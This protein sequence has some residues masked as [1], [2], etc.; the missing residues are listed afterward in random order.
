MTAVH[1]S[2]GAGSARSLKQV[3]ASQS[4]VF[5]D[6][7]ADE[8]NVI[9]L[10]QERHRLR[11]EL[12]TALERRAAMGRH[13]SVRSKGSGVR[14][15]SAAVGQR[16]RVLGYMAALV[17]VVVGGGYLGLGLRAPEYSGSTW[18]HSVSAGESLWSLAASL[19]TERPIEQVME[20][21]R[22]LNDLDADRLAVGQ[23]L[24]LPAH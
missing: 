13:P 18:E 9:D 16:M 6:L 3:S 19:E 24:V 5:P 8:D 20:D 10:G 17:A 23:M 7:P 4:P 14:A 21:I 11:P 22:H 15:G 2:E 12:A 1:L